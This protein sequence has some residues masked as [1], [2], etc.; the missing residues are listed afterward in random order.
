MR[1]LFAVLP[2]LALVPAFAPAIAYADDRP[3]VDLV[4]AIVIGAADG[5]TWSFA[6]QITGVLKQTGP[7]AFEAQT[8]NSGPLAQFAVTEK[9]KCVYDLTFSLDKQVQGGLELDAT[10]LKSVSFT[11][12]APNAGGWSDYSVTVT[13]ETGVV[14]TIAPDGTLSDAEP[15]S[16]L[17][18]SLTN[19]DLTAAATALQAICPPSE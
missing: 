12:A 6:G 16:T 9:S 8:A 1:L 14:Q 3:A 19:A 17:S 11:P 7:G 4:A 10:K 5:A 13:G 18:T 2:A 15:S